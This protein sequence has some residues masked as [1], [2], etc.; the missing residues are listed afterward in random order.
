MRVSDARFSRDIRRY[1]LAWRMIQHGVRNRAVHLWTGLSMYGIRALY[2]DYA[3]AAGAAPPPRGSL[4]SSVAY[5][6]GT[7]QTRTETALL[8]GLLEYFEVVPTD[9]SGVDALPGLAR[10]ERLCRAYEEFKTAWPAA[11]STLEHAMVLLEELV[12]GQ[13]MEAEVCGSCSSLLVRDRLSRE[14]AHCAYCLIEAWGG[15]PFAL[16]H[17]RLPEA[18]TPEIPDNVVQGQLF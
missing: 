12:R 4:P 7:F 13:E 2:K 9:G 16:R 11:Q 18:S 8:A 14:A 10:G 17:R 6:W 15:R 1:Q 5:F 3:M